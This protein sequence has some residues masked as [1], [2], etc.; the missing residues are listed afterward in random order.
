MGIVKGKNRIDENRSAERFFLWI[1]HNKSKS[2]S[3]MA[4]AQSLKAWEYKNMDYNMP[5]QCLVVQLLKSWEYKNRGYSSNQQSYVVQLLK[6][7]EYKNKVDA[8]LELDAVVQLL[9]SWEYKN[10]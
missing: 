10:D 5:G 9:K 8:E 2:I 7:W 6:S 3:W 1:Y 4:V